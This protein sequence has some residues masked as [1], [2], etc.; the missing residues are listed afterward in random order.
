M[1]PGDTGVSVLH[2]VAQNPATAR[3]AWPPPI[4]EA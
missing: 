4:H 2:V 1:R 3:G